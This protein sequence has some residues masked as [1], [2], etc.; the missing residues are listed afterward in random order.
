MRKSVDWSVV[1]LWI[2]GFA[3]HPAAS[4]QM[5][6]YQSVGVDPLLLKFFDESIE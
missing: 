3:I 4:L 5:G 6:I 1:V 2:T